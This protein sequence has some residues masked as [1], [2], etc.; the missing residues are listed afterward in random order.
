MDDIASALLTDLYQLNMIQAYLDQRF[1]AADDRRK[2]L[3]NEWLAGLRRRAE[4]NDLYMT[5]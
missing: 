4:L 2:Q 1:V 3:V 5:R